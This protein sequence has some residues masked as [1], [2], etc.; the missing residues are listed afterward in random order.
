MKL[1]FVMKKASVENNREKE[2]VHSTMSE[3][4]PPLPLPPLPP[5]PPG[6]TSQGEEVFLIVSAKVGDAPLLAH[7]DQETVWSPR[8]HLHVHADS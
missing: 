4:F 3:I 6:L 1:V 5:P 7:P 2:A 8:Q